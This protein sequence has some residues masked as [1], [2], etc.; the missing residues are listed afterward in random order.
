MLQIT[1]T[2]SAKLLTNIR[3]LFM[4][5]MLVMN[6]KKGSQKKNEPQ[7][8]KIFKTKIVNCFYSSTCTRLTCAGNVQNV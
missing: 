3:A 8:L 5:D 7:K 6:Y 4:D 1:D 2:G